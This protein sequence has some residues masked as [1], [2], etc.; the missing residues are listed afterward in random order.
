MKKALEGESSGV[1]SVKCL[2]CD[3]VFKGSKV[4]AI[5][6]TI[7]HEKPAYICPV[8]SEQFF[9]KGLMDIHVS[10]HTKLQQ[11]KSKKREKKC[12]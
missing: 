5:H 12:N 2:Y 6:T 3:L 10:E 11:R 9:S 4:Q 1:R 8:C 7:C